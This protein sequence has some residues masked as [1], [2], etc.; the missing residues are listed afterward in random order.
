MYRIT[1]KFFVLVSF[2]VACVPARAIVNHDYL[3]GYIGSNKD[4]VANNLHKN[5]NLPLYDI[6]KLSFGTNTNTSLSTDISLK[7]S[8]YNSDYQNRDQHIRI[9]SLISNRYLQNNVSRRAIPYFTGGVSGNGRSRNN[10]INGKSV[11]D[12]IYDLGIGTFVKITERLLLDLNYK[13]VDFRSERVSNIY[14]GYGSKQN[15]ASKELILNLV[16]KF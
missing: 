6:Y 12:L 11:G 13:H 4:Q 14:H 1:F 10:M 2:L 16:Y 9:Y 3:G 5:L 7:L 15:S 8:N